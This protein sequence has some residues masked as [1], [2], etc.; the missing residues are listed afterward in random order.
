MEAIEA[1]EISPSQ[2]LHSA[3]P[4]F[5]STLASSAHWTDSQISGCLFH[6]KKKFSASADPVILTLGKVPDSPTSLFKLHLLLKFLRSLEWLSFLPLSLLPPFALFSQNKSLTWNCTGLMWSVRMKASILTQLIGPQTWESPL[7]CPSASP[8][9]SCS[10]T[11]LLLSLTT[12]HHHHPDFCHRSY[13]PPPA[14]SIYRLTDFHHMSCCC[15]H[16]PRGLASAMWVISADGPT[17]TN[18][19]HVS[20]YQIAKILTQTSAYW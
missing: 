17:P 6:K 14:A 11:H 3:F 9:H 7:S 16:P 4:V 15:S 20:C 18:Q 13:R 5:F 2:H 10:A 12:H 19:F 1:D 8:V